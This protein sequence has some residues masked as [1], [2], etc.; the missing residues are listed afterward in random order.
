MPSSKYF[1]HRVTICCKCA[2]E[3]ELIAGFGGKNV[4]ESRDE[5]VFAK[6]EGVTSE[7]NQGNSLGLVNCQRSQ[8]P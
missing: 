7:T 6:S 4:V 2:T 1:C 8:S 3:S 5:I